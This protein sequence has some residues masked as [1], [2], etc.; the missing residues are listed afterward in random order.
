MNFRPLDA[1][2]DGRSLRWQAVSGTGIEHLTISASPEAVQARAVVVGERG[3]RPYGVTY[4]VIL[5]RDFTTRSFAVTA[6]DGRR[7]ALNRG[8]EGPWQDALGRRLDALEGCVDLDLAGSPFTNALPI[9]RERWRPGE[10]RP[11]SMLYVPFDTFEPRVDRQVYTCLSD[12]L[13]RYEA[14]DRTF[15]TEL[16]VDDDGLVIDYPTLFTRL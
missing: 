12:R 15:A 13:F 4:E 9:R 7:L 1:L 5:D 2:R 3:G 6:T 16:P 10:R 8:V 14:A 11:F